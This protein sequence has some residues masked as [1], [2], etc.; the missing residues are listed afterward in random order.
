[1][2]GHTP[3]IVIYFKFHRNKLRGFGA[4]TVEIWPFPLLWLLSFWTTVK[5]V[6]LKCLVSESHKPRDASHVIMIYESVIPLAV[7]TLTAFTRYLNISAC[8][9]K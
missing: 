4:R 9:G 6:V 3:D 5:T 2:Y 8:S 7:L 1:M